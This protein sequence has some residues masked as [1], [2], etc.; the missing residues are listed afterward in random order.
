MADDVER[1]QERALER[2]QPDRRVHRFGVARELER[3]QQDPT[4]WQQRPV[5]PLPNHFHPLDHRP[6]QCWAEARRTDVHGRI[7]THLR[8]SWASSDKRPSDVWH[9]IKCRCG[10][11]DIRGG[12]QIQ[13]GSRFVNVERRCLWC[14]AEATN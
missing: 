5:E 2:P 7:W 10:R 6:W 8:T 14:D 11:H 13:L 12:E 4:K 9:R 3:L 1:W